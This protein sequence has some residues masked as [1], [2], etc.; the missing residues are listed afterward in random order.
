M[1]PKLV[2]LLIVA[3]MILVGLVISSSVRTQPGVSSSMVQVVTNGV[4]QPPLAESTRSDEIWM[5]VTFY[6][7]NKASRAV[8]L[9]VAAVERKSDSSWIADTQALPAHRYSELGQVGANGITECSFVLPYE[10]VPTRLRVLVSAEATTHQ[11]A[12][13]AFRRFWANFR[14]SGSYKQLW[15]HDLFIPTYQVITPEFP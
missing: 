10:T 6:V 2:I 14:G 8:A 7:T 13:F 5:K 3:A 11:K 15:F 4:M 12:L 9:Q 1:K